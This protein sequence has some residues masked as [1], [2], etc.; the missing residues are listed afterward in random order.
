MFSP[1]GAALTLGATGF[2]GGRVAPLTLP[3]ESS[4]PFS[5]PL[6]VADIVI[7]PIPSRASERHCGLYKP[8]THFIQPSGNRV[9]STALLDVCGRIFRP[10]LHLGTWVHN[11][12]DRCPIEDLLMLS[13]PD[14]F[15]V[16]FCR[17]ILAGFFRTEAS[18]HASCCNVF[19]ALPTSACCVMSGLHS[20]GTAWI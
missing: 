6:A 14:G 7:S 18:S 20:R 9:P 2:V 16:H 8:K 10:S 17:L 4:L 15:A 13:Y 11:L 1:S 19:R 12:F 5:K 3:D